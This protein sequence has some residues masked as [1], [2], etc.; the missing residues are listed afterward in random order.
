M[1]IGDLVVRV[2]A[3]IGGFVRDMDT[4]EARVG[5]FRGQV[6]RGA[7]AVGKYAAAATAAGAAIAVGITRSA[8]QAGQELANLSRLSNT[9][10]TS[11]QRNAIAA[12]TVGIEQQKLADIYKDMQDRVGDFIQTGG[13]PMADFFERIA[14]QVGVTVE[15]FR[16]LSGPQGLQLF[17]DSLEKANLSQSEM[18]FQ[19]E[20][21]ASDSSLLIPLLSDGGSVIRQMG[22]EAERTGRILSE[23][24]VKRLQLAAQEMV[25][26][27]QLMATVR[28]QVG[29]QLA[30]LMAGLGKLIEDAA[31]EAGGFGNVIDESMGTGI[32]AVGNLADVLHGM[33]LVIK[34]V[35][36]GFE[37]AALLMATT[38]SEAGNGIMSIINGVID[39]ING[40]ITQANKIK[41]VDINLLENVDTP[42]MLQVLNDTKKGLLDSVAET[43]QEMND[44]LAEPMPSDRLK[45]WTDSVKTEFDKAALSVEE[46]LNSAM[47]GVGGGL[48]AFGEDEDAKDREKQI[49][50][51]MQALADENARRM[52]LFRERYFGEEEL[53]KEHEERMRELDAAFREQGLI[54][55]QEYNQFR[56]DNMR[57][58]MEQQFGIQSSG[59][60]AMTDMVAKNFGAQKA[61]AVDA[62][63]SIV[64]SM[65]GESKKAFEIQ[66]ALGIANTIINTID[67]AQ[68]AYKFGANIGGPILGGV[69]AAAAAAQGYAR[70]QQIRSQSFGG[71]GSAAGAAGSGGGGQV[72]AATSEA[73]RG[74]GGGGTIINIRGV[75]PSQIY[76]GEQIDGLI[77]AINER[78]DQGMTIRTST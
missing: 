27:D 52:D 72:Q 61:I 71:G 22:D 7:I 25:N 38:W 40:L 65:A 14:P 51:R 44:L 37:G 17:V 11:F 24:D 5:K 34:G 19:M 23:M 8:A 42:E 21:I 50:Q 78:G 29:A 18:V 41:G 10:T 60:D 67:A 46:R 57:D 13:G 20:A 2:G 74:T 48:S 43:K 69:M 6:N 31:I 55:E 47:S 4:A 75:D 16:K 9:S 63:G 73:V 66:K 59:Y 49:E 3:D 28:N 26:F 58:Y 30:P 45:E 32:K 15:Q 54:N 70:V 36:M 76:T 33:H 62:L 56:L 77:S 12:R 39:G 64:N 1:A 35:E 68:G 53:R